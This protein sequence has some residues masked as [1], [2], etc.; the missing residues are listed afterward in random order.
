MRRF[1]SSIALI[2]G[3]AALVAS[4]SDSTAPSGTETPDVAALLSEMSL[5][6]VVGGPAAAS[7]P[8]AGAF[9]DVGPS[10]GRNACTFSSAS[11]GFTCP[12]VS[13]NGLTFTRSYWLLDGAGQPQSKPDANTASIRTLTTVKG[14]LTV[15]RPD[16]GPT[17][18]VT[19]DR[20]ED[21]TLSAIRTTHRTLNGTA[22]S[23]TAGTLT[24]VNGT[25]DSRS[26]STERIVNLVLPDPR[27][28]KRWPQSG[29]IIVDAT[30]TVTPNGQQTFTSTTH[31]EISYD[32]TSVVTITLTTGFGTRTCKIDMTKPSPGVCFV[33]ARA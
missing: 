6:S 5:S 4:C 9:L 32:G 21:M 29:Q 30:S 33:D 12:A 23:K 1:Y 17:S 15:S 18:S 19:V 8:V 20:T 11:G 7:V 25:L 10:A 27:S 31:T 3:A 13:I 24:T 22:T 26:E 2:I 14:T 28:G 16:G